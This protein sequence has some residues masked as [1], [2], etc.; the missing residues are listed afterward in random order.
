PP[1]PT[2]RSS[3]LLR[4]DPRNVRTLYASFSAERGPILVDGAPVAESTPVDTDFK[5]QR[6]YNNPL[7][8]SHVTGYYTLNQGNAGIEGALNDYLT[9]TANAPSVDLLSSL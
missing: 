1:F 4:A 6:V 7:L 3:D 5:F 9:G 2:R 8:Y